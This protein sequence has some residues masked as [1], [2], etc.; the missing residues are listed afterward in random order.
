DQQQLDFVLGERFV[1]DALWNNEHLARR[2]MD[3]AVAKVDAQLAFDND[4]RLVGVLVVMPDEI[5]PELDDLELV[6]VHL[7]DDLGLPLFAKQCEF[8]REVDG[9]VAHAPSPAS[10]THSLY[11]K[12]RRKPVLNDCAPRAPARGVF[13]FPRPGSSM[14]N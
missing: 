2:D 12:P 13:N 4:E 14:F 8:L 9:S 6:V 7:R 5:A 10:T 1:L 11:I 3:G